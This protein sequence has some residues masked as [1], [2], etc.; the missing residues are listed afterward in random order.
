MKSTDGNSEDSPDEAF[1]ELFKLFS[2]PTKSPQKA[3]R[4]YQLTF[5]N[6]EPIFTLSEV[7]RMLEE[8]FEEIFDPGSN[9]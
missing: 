8:V 1:A 9:E 3:Y 7:D 2:K 5:E 4:T 6:G